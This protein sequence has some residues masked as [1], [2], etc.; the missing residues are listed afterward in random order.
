MAGLE[1]HP[2]QNGLK[3]TSQNELIPPWQKHGNHATPAIVYGSCSGW[4]LHEYSSDF[5]PKYHS[6]A[7]RSVRTLTGRCL[8][9]SLWVIKLEV[10]STCVARNSTI[11]S[12]TRDIGDDCPLPSVSPS[13]EP[14]TELANCLRTTIPAPLMMALS[15]APADSGIVGNDAF[16]SSGPTGLKYPLSKAP[17]CRF[18]N[19]KGLKGRHI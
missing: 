7:L 5:C 6:M 15:S 19:E 16:C 9:S 13:S 10:P 11:S 4:N 14:S 8:F 2:A 1:F 18:P 12:K 17:D 3:P